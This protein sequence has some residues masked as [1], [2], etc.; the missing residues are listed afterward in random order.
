MNKREIQVFRYFALKTVSLRTDDDEHPESPGLTATRGGE[1]PS[2]QEVAEMFFRIIE[3]LNN[4][5]Q[6]ETG[7]VAA[8][9]GVIIAGI[10]VVIAVAAAALGGRIGALFDSVL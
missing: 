7:G 5:G 6:D 4:A 3:R 10:A 9:Y 2:K 8:E 1:G